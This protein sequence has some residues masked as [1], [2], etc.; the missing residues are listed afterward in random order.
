MR[1]FKIVDF[2]YFYRPIAS[3][4]KKLFLFSLPLFALLACDANDPDNVVQEPPRERKAVIAVEGISPNGISWVGEYNITGQ[5]LNN[6]V[7][8]KANQAPLGFGLSDFLLDEE[9]GIGLFLME[10]SEKIVVADLETYE[11]IKTISNLPRIKSIIKVAPQTYYVTSWEENAIFMIKGKNFNVRGPELTGDGPLAM[12]QWND[13]VF[14]ANN[15]GDYLD[16]TVSIFRSTADTLVA[17]IRSGVRPNSMVID[18]NNYLWILASGEVNQI[19]PTA[20]GPGTLVRYQ[21][22]S[23]KMAIDSGTTIMPDTA[24]VFN[25]N[26]L[27][28]HSLVI[29]K[30]GGGELFY[31]SNQPTGDILK[32]GLND[33]RVGEG[34]YITGNYY[35]LGFDQVATEL[36]GLNTPSSDI[37]GNGS[38]EIFAPDGSLKNSFLIGPKPT[39]VAFK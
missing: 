7:Y 37:N 17:V 10:G 28:P 21:L 2:Y 5:Y 6:N 19:D 18:Q 29:N 27:K 20:S 39:S 33:T 22:D 14:V 26:Q 11:L 3:P 23:M 38:V 35:S 4:M 36:Y 30:Q 24:F 16:S 32:M 1:V 15:G 13:L 12:K 34:P 25:D 31:I 9:A 8:Q